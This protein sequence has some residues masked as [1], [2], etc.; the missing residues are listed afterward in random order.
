M[1]HVVVVCEGYT[2]QDFVRD[3]LA[4]AL[5]LDGISVG[6]QSIATS[7]IGKG[8]ALSRD[9]MLRGL[10]N[11]AKQRTNAYITT[12]F[13]LYALKP[14]VP[15]VAEARGRG[16]PRERSKR[17]GEAISQWVVDEVG[18]LPQR[19]FAHIQP[20]EFEGLLF[21]DPARLCE[22]ERTWGRFVEPLQRV[23][24]DSPSPEH[25][26]DGPNTHP[27]ARLNVLK[28]PAYSKRLHGPQAA[29]R[30]GLDRIASECQ[31]F[32]AW[33]ARLRTLPPLPT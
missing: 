17:I 21:S 1:T 9:R 3:V 24:A 5:A 16:D 14:D 2:E 31:H 33:L 13:D 11:T 15:G 22:V 10:A 28:G 4:P 32:G 7:S 27:A 29:A 12:F 23:R 25:I 18:C 30:I 26:N 20:Y 8:G 6:R 19:F